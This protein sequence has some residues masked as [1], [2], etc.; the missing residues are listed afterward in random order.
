M[1]FQA[2]V[3]TQDR[4]IRVMLGI[5]LLLVSLVFPLVTTATGKIIVSVIGVILL[6][7]GSISY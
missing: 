4:I 1:T 7:T 3:G 2:N 6:V 5:A